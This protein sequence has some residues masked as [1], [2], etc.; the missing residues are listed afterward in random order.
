M[1]ISPKDQVT[2]DSYS[3]KKWLI[4][5][6]SAMCVRSMTFTKCHSSSSIKM[7]PGMTAAEGA[8]LMNQG[9]CGL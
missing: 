8:P 7:L 6:I 5:L 9:F 3:F 4:L 1:S 2:M